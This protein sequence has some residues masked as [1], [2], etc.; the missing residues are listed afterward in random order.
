MPGCKNHGKWPC[1][2]CLTINIAKYEIE[3]EERIK[4]GR[5]DLHDIPGLKKELA[6]I[7]SNI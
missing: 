6:R 7:E 3:N 1:A 4:A 2:I 5:T